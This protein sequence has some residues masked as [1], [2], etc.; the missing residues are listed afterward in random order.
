ME[1][2][3]FSVQAKE[4]RRRLGSKSSALRESTK[5]KTLIDSRE[6]G[7]FI[8]GIINSLVNS[9]KKNSSTMKFG[10]TLLCSLVPFLSPENWK[11]FKKRMEEIRLETDENNIKAMSANLWEDCFGIEGAAL[12][13]GVVADAFSLMTAT[14]ATTA[15]V[16]AEAENLISVPSDISIFQMEMNS[17]WEGFSYGFLV[18]FAMDVVSYAWQYTVTY[19]NDSKGRAALSHPTE[20]AS[21]IENVMMSAFGGL[22]GVLGASLG[23]NWILTLISGIAVSLVLKSYTIEPVKQMVGTITLIDVAS[24]AWQGLKQAW[25]I[26]HRQTIVRYTWQWDGAHEPTDEDLTCPISF[27]YPYYPCFLHGHVYDRYYL[28]RWLTENN[29]CPLTN[30]PASMDDVVIDMEYSRLS[31]EYGSLCGGQRVIEQRD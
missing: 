24:F 3:A 10:N 5:M 1:Y 27:R 29:R 13:N 18:K 25:G 7:R 31:I 6:E 4:V 2:N 8:S 15:S 12:M 14:T 11:K 22:T 20:I 30:L 28:E 21:I 26:S 17:V 9:F 16:V 19:R 23:F